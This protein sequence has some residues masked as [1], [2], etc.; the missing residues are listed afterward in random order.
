MAL[1]RR[2][3]QA[4]ES[5]SLT[6]K[7]RMLEESRSISWVGKPTRVCDGKVYY[8]AISVEDETFAVGSYAR[9]AVGTGKSGSR[10]THVSSH[11]RESPVLSDFP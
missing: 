9:F 11:E 10:I 2:Q 3:K 8:S 6:K 5:S 7:Q 4:L 1:R